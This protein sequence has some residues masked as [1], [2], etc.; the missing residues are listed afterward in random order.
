MSQYLLIWKTDLG[1]IY[2]HRYLSKI[3]SLKVEKTTLLLSLT[4]I[5]M[6][7]KI[8]VQ[9]LSDTMISMSFILL[10]CWKNVASH[11]CL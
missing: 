6:K 10:F 2:N 1:V 9:Q 7:G 11:T 4:M 5:I 8:S 3:E